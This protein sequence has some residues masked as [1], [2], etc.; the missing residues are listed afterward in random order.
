MSEPEARFRYRLFDADGLPWP[1]RIGWA[2]LVLLSSATGFIAAIVLG[3]YLG[4]WLRGKRRSALPLFIYLIIAAIYPLVVA[5]AFAHLA[6]IADGLGLLG[7]T[8][9]FIGACTLRHQVILY[10]SEREG[11]TFRINRILTLLFS[12]WYI[13]GSLRAD[14]PLDHAGK[15][16]SGVLK[17][18]T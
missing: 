17:L 13:C 4:I 15:L 10:Y 18:T 12:V 16:P 5:A 14:F 11:A 8:L 9:W 6:S 2:W 1:S 3:I 7:L